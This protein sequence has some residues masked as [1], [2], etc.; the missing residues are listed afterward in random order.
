MLFFRNTL[1]FCPPRR[2]GEGESFGELIDEIFRGAVSHHIGNIQNFQI[3]IHQQKGS[4]VNFL[5]VEEIDDCLVE[6]FFKLPAHISVAV[7]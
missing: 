2:G 6:V 4:T 7:G 1:I 5:L 3:G